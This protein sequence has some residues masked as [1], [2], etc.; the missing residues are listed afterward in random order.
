[1]LQMPNVII[2][3]LTA[4]NFCSKKPCKNNGTCVNGDKG[5]S[6]DCL[7]NFLGKNCEG[8]KLQH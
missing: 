2:C 4:V 8:L 7:Q 6:C 1:M 5:Y 3:V